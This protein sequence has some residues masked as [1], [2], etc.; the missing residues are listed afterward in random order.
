MPRTVDGMSLLG[1]KA[2][3]DYLGISRTTLHR[4]TVEGKLLPDIV[5][6]GGQ[7]R[8]KLATLDEYRRRQ[9]RGRSV[10]EPAPPLDVRRWE[11]VGQIARLIAAGR[12]DEEVCRA[13]LPLIYDALPGVE[14]AY[15][16]IARPPDYDLLEMRRYGHGALETGMM[17]TFRAL[18]PRAGYLTPRLIERG[19]IIIFDDMVNDPMLDGSESS[20]FVQQF[21]IRSFVGMPLRRDGVPIGLLGI[22]SR[23]SHLFHSGEILYLSAV[24]DVLVG[25]L[26]ALATRTEL[27]QA[28]IAIARLAAEGLRVRQTNGRS[29]AERTRERLASLID[30]YRTF[31]GA[32]TVGIRGLGHD[33]IP[34]HGQLTRLMRTA[35]TPGMVAL[36]APGAEER[37]ESCTCLAI[38]AAQAD[39]TIGQI[40]AAWHGQRQFTAQDSALFTTFATVCLLTITHLSACDR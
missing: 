3:A 8:F 35:T 34:A 4:E 38:A 1:A 6:R 30:Q 18:G 32:H 19:D 40:G 7:R 9:S 15:L 33:I 11:S 37:G 22:G 20:V 31:S 21:G 13:A 16:V 27:G 29:A 17:D 24:A 12:T 39:G 14:F 25:A 10:D 26:T 28:H 23:T 5:T 36:C 2:A